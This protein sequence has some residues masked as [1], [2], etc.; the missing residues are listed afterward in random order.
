[1]A[2]FPGETGGSVIEA[3]QGVHLLVSVIS[4]TV[5]CRRSVDNCL[6][7]GSPVAVASS[8]AAIAP[9]IC[10]PTSKGRIITW[11]IDSTGSLLSKYSDDQGKTWT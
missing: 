7:W 2:A 6:T 3:M 5:R 1:M 9:S 10:G 8:A 11:Y 4:A